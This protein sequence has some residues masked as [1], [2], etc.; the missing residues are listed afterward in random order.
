MVLIKF[1]AATEGMIT[2]CCRNIFVYKD[3]FLGNSWWLILP[4]S[5]TNI[6]LSDC[7]GLEALGE[8]ENATMDDWQGINFKQ[9]SLWQV[10][11]HRSTNSSSKPRGGGCEHLNLRRQVSERAGLVDHFRGLPELISA[12]EGELFRKFD[13]NRCLQHHR[14]CPPDSRLQQPGTLPWLQGMP[15]WRISSHKVIQS[16]MPWLFQALFYEVHLR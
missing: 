1:H 13:N 10:S 3:S 7:R 2:V 6:S 5:A 16:H 15:G 4:Y 14:A 8:R 12:T 11:I 9:T